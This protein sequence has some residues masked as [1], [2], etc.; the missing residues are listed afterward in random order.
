MTSERCYLMLKEG[1][2]GRIQD[3]DG[4]RRYVIVKIDDRLYYQFFEENE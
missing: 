3:K 4:I 1:D 2:T